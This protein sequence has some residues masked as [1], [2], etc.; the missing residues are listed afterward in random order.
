MKLFKDLSPAEEREFRD[1][2]QKNYRAFEPIQGT[3]HP[4]VQDEC[5]KINAAAEFST[6]QILPSKDGKTGYIISKDFPEDE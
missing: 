5:V 3:W 1:W 6:R 2:A 4:V